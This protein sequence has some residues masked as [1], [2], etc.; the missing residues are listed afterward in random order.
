VVLEALAVAHQVQTRTAQAVQVQVQRVVRS[1]FWSDVRMTCKFKAYLREETRELEPS[2]VQIRK[3]MIVGLV[4]IALF[5]VISVQAQNASRP[6]T[7]DEIQDIC[8]GHK[9]SEV[10]SLNCE[11]ISRCLSYGS[12]ISKCYIDSK[13]AT[14][15]D[16]DEND[17]LYEEDEDGNKTPVMTSQR[18]TYIM[19]VCTGR[20]LIE[21]LSV[22]G[23]CFGIQLCLSYKSM[24]ECYTDLKNGEILNF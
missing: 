6:F 8:Q 5:P 14:L 3:C 24:S 13:E 18:A 2:T 17:T 23:Y 22:R 15:V 16:H 7:F 10:P 21:D 19:N 1:A 20:I 9:L 12:S 4:F 11:Y